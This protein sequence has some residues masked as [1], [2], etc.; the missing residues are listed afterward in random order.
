M[1]QNFIFREIYTH[2]QLS[3]HNTHSW[4]AS[5]WKNQDL[6]VT[7]ILREIN[8]QDSTSAKSAFAI[9]GA[10]KIVDLV[11]FSLQR[12]QKFTKNQNSQ[13]L[14]MCEMADFALL[15]SPKLISRKQLFLAGQK[16]RTLILMI[17]LTFALPTKI[18]RNCHYFH[19]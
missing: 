16:K 18:C 15:E 17:S 12:M 8:F 10:L 3:H 14:Q 6:S 4:C 9:L 1:K 13:S 11:N 19:L 7:Q 5:M 2:K